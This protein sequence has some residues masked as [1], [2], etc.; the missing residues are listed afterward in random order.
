MSEQSPSGS[1]KPRHVP[2]RTCVAC[3]TSGQKRGLIRVVR[4]TDGSV[5]VDMSGKANGRGAYLCFELKCIQQARKQKKLDRGLK[6]TVPP[7]IYDEIEQIA[8]N[9]E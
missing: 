4:L 7:S 6:V 2:V 5:L 8:T 1:R 9:E 3:R